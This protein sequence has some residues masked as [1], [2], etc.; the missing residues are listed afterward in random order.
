MTGTFSYCTPTILDLS[1]IKGIANPWEIINHLL[2][3]VKIKKKIKMQVSALLMMLVA[4]LCCLMQASYACV[5]DGEPCSTDFTT[6]CCS[7][8]CLFQPGDSEG[9]CAPRS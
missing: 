6:D 4:F 2:F 3:K 5:P 9:R 7:K 8:F 1:D